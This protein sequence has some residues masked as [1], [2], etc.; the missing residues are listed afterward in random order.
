MFAGD[1][2]AFNGFVENYVETILGMRPDLKKDQDDS[3]SDDNDED[4]YEQMNQ[5]MSRSGSKYR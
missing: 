4:D 3:D 1:D 5:S 2:K